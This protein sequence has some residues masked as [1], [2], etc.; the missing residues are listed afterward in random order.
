MLE[1][2]GGGKRLESPVHLAFQQLR[3]VDVE[4]FFSW[5]GREALVEDKVS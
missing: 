4:R 5:L 1:W 3:M 2:V